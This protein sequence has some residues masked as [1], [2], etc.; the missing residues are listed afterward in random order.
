[1]QTWISFADARY[2]DRT[3]ES[4]VCCTL[5]WQILLFRWFMVCFLDCKFKGINSYW[6]NQYLPLLYILP[7]IVKM[8]RSCS[9]HFL[10]IFI[11]WKIYWQIF[12]HRLCECGCCHE[13]LFHLIEF[14]A[15]T[16]LSW[17]LSIQIWYIMCCLICFETESQ[18]RE[19]ERRKNRTMFTLLLCA[20]RI[21]NRHPAFCTSKQTDRLSNSSLIRCHLPIN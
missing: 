8:S 16:N 6:E 9:S 21:S 20:C 3:V 15:A 4:I 2:I 19:R 14:D 5:K 1:M 7:E 13:Q 17:A 18:T 12:C 11:Y 10:R